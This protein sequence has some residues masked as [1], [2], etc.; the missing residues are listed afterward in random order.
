MKLEKKEFGRMLEEV[1]GRTSDVSFLSNWAY[2]IF[3]DRQHNMDAEV[4]ELL[5]DLN[6]M[7]DGP[8]FEFTTGELS[9][10]ARKLQG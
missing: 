3:L 1:L 7:D 10:I 5:L 8:E 4:R 2:E 6:H 9:E